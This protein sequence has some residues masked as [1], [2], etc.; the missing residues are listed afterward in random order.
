MDY[1]NKIICGD[2][3]ET[4]KK[5]PNDCVHLIFSS[6]PYNVSINY[7]TYKDNKKW[8]AYLHWLNDIWKECFRVLVDGGRLIIN[9]DA[10]TNLEDK[11]IDKKE[12][13]R[14][15]HAELIY[16]MR[17][18]PESLYRGEICWCKQNASGKKTCWGSWKSPSSPHIRRNHEMLYIWYKNK[19]TLGGDKDK[20]DITKDEFVNWTLSTWE[21]KP[22]TRK[23]AGHDAPFPEELAKRVIK[24]FSYQENVVMDIFSGTGTTAYVAKLLNR[25]YIGIDCSK[26]Y[27]EFAEQRIHTADSILEFTK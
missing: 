8:D 19:W 20:I 5:M 15:I 27:C 18:I 25:K 9:I 17:Q 11:G 1:F 21:I 22:E 12:Y 6:P 13:V 24:L 14:P 7:D 2:T 26:T 16:Q 23:L 3:L 4:L 10:I